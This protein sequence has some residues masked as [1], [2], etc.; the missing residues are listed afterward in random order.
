MNITYTAKALYQGI[1]VK[2]SIASKEQLLITVIPLTSYGT[3]VF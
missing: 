3:K 2:T 1:P